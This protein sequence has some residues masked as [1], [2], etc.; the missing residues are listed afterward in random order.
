MP[1]HCQLPGEAA[2]FTCIVSRRHIVTYPAIADIPLRQP[3]PAVVIT[4]TIQALC[5]RYARVRTA[6]DIMVPPRSTPGSAAG[7]SGEQWLDR[8]SRRG[9][10]PPPWVR[11]QHRHLG[12]GVIAWWVGWRHHIRQ[13][14]R[15]YRPLRL[16]SDAHIFVWIDGRNLSE[17]SEHSERVRPGATSANDLYPANCADRRKPSDRPTCRAKRDPAD[18]VLIS[19]DPRQRPNC[20]G[21]NVAKGGGANASE[22]SISPLAERARSPPSDGD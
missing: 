8:P 14:G 3:F 13:D 18:P 10:A 19:G 17:R 1:R 16:G 4:P 9:S 12:S 20:T 2:T 22:A 21:M 5:A 11:R 7:R 15:I 6:I